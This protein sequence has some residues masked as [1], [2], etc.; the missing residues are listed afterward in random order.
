M[1]F[2]VPALAAETDEVLL[3]VSEEVYCADVVAQIADSPLM[4]ADVGNQLDL[5][6]SFY[7][8]NFADQPIAIFYKLDP[9][10]YAIY[11]FTG[12]TVLEY[13]TECDHPFYTDAS[14]RYYYEGVFN[15]YKA[16]DGGFEN[17]ATGQIKSV[18]SEYEFTASD[19]YHNSENSGIATRASEGPVYLEND[20]RL[21]DCNTADNLSYFYPNLSQADLDDCPGICGSLACA[22]LIAYFDD[23]HPDLAGSGDFAKN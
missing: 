5:E 9:V 4:T 23:Y 19:F 10:G 7:L 12:S 20:T 13:T 2:S 8:Y 3:D 17:L 11:G 21:Y 15:Y 14:Q 18:N 1:A 22:V 6:D 16:V